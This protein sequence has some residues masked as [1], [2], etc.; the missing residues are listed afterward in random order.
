LRFGEPVNAKVTAQIETPDRGPLVQMVVDRGGRGERPST[1]I[2]IVDV[3]GLLVNRL[4][5][6]KLNG[7]STGGENPVDLFREKLDA[8]ASDPCICAVVLRINTPGGGV[9]ATDIMWRELKDFR[10]RSGRPVVACLMDLATGGGYYLA[11]G[12]DVI[13][14]HPTTVTGG[15]GVILNHYN[16]Q[17]TLAQYNVRS[18]PIKA[19]ENIDMG[20]AAVDMPPEV[21]DWLQ[22]MADEYHQ[23]FTQ[24]VVDS[25]PRVRADNGQIFDGRI[26]TA[27]QALQI[28]LV[29]Q[30]GYLQDAVDAAL[31]RAG[32]NDACVVMFR[33]RNDPAR[34]PYAITANQSISSGLLPLSIP[35]LERSKL[36]A[37]LYMWQAEPTLER[38]AGR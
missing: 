14:A 7:S 23:R 33:P 36:P 25:R 30:V 1:K 38:L 19:G 5:S 9:A 2:G 24:V 28:G 15:I 34:T 13:Y 20:T 27:Q 10:S 32:Q 37:F 11:T 26:F 18:E 22:A 16:L 17:D 4:V 3:D 12:A 29:D 35:G 8:A 21:R 31:E 6:T